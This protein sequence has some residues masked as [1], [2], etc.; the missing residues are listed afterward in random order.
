MAIDTMRWVLD[1]AQQGVSSLHFE[2]SPASPSSSLGPEDVLVEI[3]AASLNYRDLA[4][5]KVSRLFLIES[6]A[7][8][9][10]SFHPM[11]ITDYLPGQRRDS[12]RCQPE[13]GT[14]F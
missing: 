6:K 11:H 5:A 13:C 4:I 9:G 1:E 7:I 2:S 3:R 10:F 12:T 8:I 14:G